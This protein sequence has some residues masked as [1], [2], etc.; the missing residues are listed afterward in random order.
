MAVTNR[1]NSYEGGVQLNIYED[2]QQAV[3]T[4]P[5]IHG[6]IKSGV[7]MKSLIKIIHGMDLDT[8]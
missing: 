1:I 7:L 3:Q 2:Y 4:I 6:T 5:S 8:H